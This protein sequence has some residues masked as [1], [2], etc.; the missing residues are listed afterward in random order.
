MRGGCSTGWGPLARR[1]GIALWLAGA[2]RLAV[3]PASAPAAGAAALPH[4]HTPTL[5]HS[6]IA[7]LV[8]IPAVSLDDLVSTPT[9]GIRSLLDTGAV[10]ILNTRTGPSR[11][12]R[13][14][15][16]IDSLVLHPEE[17]RPTTIEAGCLTLGAG[18]RCHAR[19]EA[20]EAFE[21]DEV[22]DGIRA[23]DLWAQRTG[24]PVTRDRI[25]QVAIPRMAGRHERLSYAARPGALGQA[26]REAGI[27]AA[28]VGNADDDAGP[29]RE[30]ACLAMDTR[31]R[32]PLGRVGPEMATPDPWTPGGRRTNAEAVLRGVT[33]ALG[34]GARFVVVDTGD[35]G[36]VDRATADI[37]EEVR[38]VRRREAIRHADRIVTGLRRL[39]DPAGTLLILVAP[40]VSLDAARDGN[41]LAPVILAGGGRER[42]VILSPSTRT[43]GLGVNT[44]IA[45]TILD[46]L[47]APIPADMIGR[48]LTA[49]RDAQAADTVLAL[50]RRFRQVEDYGR[51]LVR[52]LVWGQVALFGAFLLFLWAR[53]GACASQR[54]VLRAGALAVAALP[55]AVL[56]VGLFAPASP[57]VG[58]ALMLLLLAGLAGI[59]R[60]AGRWVSPVGFLWLLGGALWG[61][62]LLTGGGLLRASPLGYSPYSGARYYGIGNEGFGLL[63]P[64]LLLGA[65]CAACG[66]GARPAREA[67][68]GR[69]GV[70]VAG[71]LVLLTAA[72]VGHPAFGANFGGALGAAAAGA[73]AIALALRGRVRRRT[74]VG[75]GLAGLAVM[76]LPVCLELLSG[77]GEQSHIGRALA[78]VSAGGP[79]EAWAVAARKL[80]MNWTL[81]RHSPWSRLLVL[82]TAAAL[83]LALRGRA[84]LSQQRPAL[85]DGL[86]ALA[87]GA[88]ASLLF[89]DSGVLP[90]AEMAAAGAA[91]LVVF[92]VESE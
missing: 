19:T 9:E 27:L 88:A 29:H 53:P 3:G 49:R 57:P 37:Q 10:G 41:P 80:K 74:L 31:G 48:P 56:L 85:R 43:P 92:A 39:L 45:P 82:A 5:P 42:G 89:N 70:L 22:V 87:A 60:L 30:A 77:A 61:C 16:A 1:L 67:R 68:S 75:V 72:L 32:V 63:V 7:V 15:R 86:L 50:E 35:T 79:G 26:L 66:L 71:V 90:A 78:L 34:A 21:A 73:S 40:V 25:F 36:R 13:A 51:P 84:A 91:A 6:R 55:A 47:G 44:D 12:G 64:A 46:F 24:L 20:G 59:G 8:L 69:A 14:N 17:V 62:D 81:L 18:A 83:A 38:P 54:G 58:G 33:E 52:W 11:A 76:A 4:P 28:A 65:T 2:V 23:A